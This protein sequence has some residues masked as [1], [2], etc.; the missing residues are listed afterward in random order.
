MKAHLLQLRHVGLIDL[1]ERG[2]LHGIRRAAVIP[3][4]GVRRLLLREGDYEGEQQSQRRGGQ[5]CF[6]G[7]LYVLN[8]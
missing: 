7:S 6:H 5:F 3:P 8:L 2:V 4:S 1:L